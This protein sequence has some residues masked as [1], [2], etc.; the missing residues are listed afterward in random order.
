[1]KP[2]KCVVKKLTKQAYDDASNLKISCEHAKTRVYYNVFTDI[3]HTTISALI[4]HVLSQK[5]F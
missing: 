5:T 2:Q 1:M 4:I 3:D